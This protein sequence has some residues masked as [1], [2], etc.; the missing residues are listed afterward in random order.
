MCQS[1]AYIVVVLVS[2]AA[3][4]VAQMTSAVDITKESV[5]HLSKQLT[6]TCTHTRKKAE[7]TTENI[8][9]VQNKM[10][11]ENNEQEALLPGNVIELIAHQ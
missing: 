6:H 5:C 11:I 7:S 9:Y 1:T 4:A 3:Y 10:Q 2:A 8:L